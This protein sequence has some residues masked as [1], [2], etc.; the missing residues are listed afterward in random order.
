MLP[1]TQGKFREELKRNTVFPELKRDYIPSV[2]NFKYFRNIVRRYVYQFKYVLDF[3]LK[4]NREQNVIGLYN[5]HGSKA[6]GIITIFIDGIPFEFGKHFRDTYEPKE[7][8]KTFDEY[9]TLFE[10]K[11]LTLEDVSDNATEM[12]DLFMDPRKDK[13]FRLHSVRDAEDSDVGVLYY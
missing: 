7:K 9:L 13:S 4:G 6:P 11:F 12:D 5:T 3:L 10:K 8:V 2:T 1:K